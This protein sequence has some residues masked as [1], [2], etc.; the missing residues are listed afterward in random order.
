MA[1]LFN[2]FAGKKKKKIVLKSYTP[3]NTIAAFIELPAGVN[4]SEAIWHTSSVALDTEQICFIYSLADDGVYFVAAPAISFLKHPVS[5][6]PLAAALPGN[7][8]HQGDG[9]YIT[10]IGSNLFA[11]TIKGA[12]SLSCY[13]GDKASVVQFAENN[14]QFWVEENTAPWLSMTQYKQKETLKLL[15]TLSLI[16]FCLIFMF[17]GASAFF[18][19][20][21]ERYVAQTKTKK[22][23]ILAVEQKNLLA[24]N[25]EEQNKSENQVLRK[26]LE[27][28]SYVISQNGRIVHYEVRAKRIKYQVELPQTATNLTFFG[29]NVVPVVKQDV[30]IIDKEELL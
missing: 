4:P 13:I 15:N 6:T 19:Q 17:L 26:Y 24:L 28:S 3:K 11:V 22:Q 25:M 16:S 21:S 20:Q 8:G 27:L 7:P 1:N 30:I 2:K 29:K 12:D 18:N 14:P 10:P 23:K 5:T 9:A